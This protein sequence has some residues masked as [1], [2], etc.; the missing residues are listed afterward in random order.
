M[1]EFT[2]ICPLQDS[3]VPR[4][5]A[6]AGLIWRAHYPG[7]ISEAQIEYML[8]ERYDA[9]LIREELRRGDLWWDVLLLNGQMTGYTS[10]FL[11]DVP[12]TIKI[13]KLYL[14]PDVHR[15]G[16]GGMLIDHVA[17]RAVQCGRTRLMLA[18]N[19]HNKTAVA[20]YRRHGFAIINTSLKKI[21]GDFWMDDYIMSKSVGG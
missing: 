7:I 12:D 5:S 15:R 9:S 21:G 8:A 17:A 13:D 6:L 1:R 16:Y 19:R 20:A 3:D 11:T 2:E 4:L 14:H 10:Y 18:V